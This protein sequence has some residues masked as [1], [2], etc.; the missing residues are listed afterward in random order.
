[1][2]INLGTAFEDR[3]GQEKNKV[4][5]KL[6]MEKG[7]TEEQIGE[8]VEI[9]IEGVKVFDE[10]IQITLPSGNKLIGPS[11]SIAHIFAR[12]T[13]VPPMIAASEATEE[14]LKQM[15]EDGSDEETGS[16]AHV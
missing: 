5:K 9:F 13:M 12:Y 6:N 4:C 15:N 14:M 2:T 3:K 8:E 11:L 1:M 16:P 10:V 7:Y